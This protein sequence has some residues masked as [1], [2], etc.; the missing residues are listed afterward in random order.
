MHQKI[1]ELSPDSYI[2]VA[3]RISEGKEKVVLALRGVSD[4][5]SPALA[6]VVINEPELEA[7]IESLEYLRD[8]DSK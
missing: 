7:L 2:E 3:T 1:I 8:R 5:N 6:S 4:M